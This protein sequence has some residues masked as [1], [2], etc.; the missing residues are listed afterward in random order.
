MTRPETQI[1][2]NATTERAWLAET[3]ENDA[4]QE[5]VDLTV[6]NAPDPGKL[7]T[8]PMAPDGRAGD[9]PTTQ[10][11]PAPGAEADSTRSGLGSVGDYELIEML[12]RGGMGIVYKA[13][14]VSLNRLVALKL[15]KDAE[16]ASAS[17]RLRFQNEAEAVAQLDHPHIV[18][19]YE[20]GECRGRRYFS[21]K[22]IAGTGLDKHL[23]DFLA[24]PRAAARLVAVIA[25]AV[26]HAHER[27]ILHRDLK[28]GNILVD[29]RGQPHV[30]D[31][32]LAK[33]ITTESGLTHSGAIMGTPLYMS[34]EQAS[35]IKGANTTAT[36]VYGLGSILYALLA[37]RAPFSTGSVAE[38]LDLVRHRPPEPPS[39]RNP[40]VPRDLEVICLKC[41][42]KEPKRRYPSALALAE[43]LSRWLEGK[44]IAARPVGPLPRAGMW[45]RRNPLPAG[46]AFLLAIALLGGL[47]GIVWKWREADR[48]RTKATAINELLTRRLLAQAAPEFQPR[49]ANVT[50]LD[51]LDRAGAQLGGWLNGQAD[52]EAAV[53]ET[54]GG[55]Y[56]SLGRYDKAEEHLRAAIRLATEAGGPEQPDVLR[57]VNL[58]AAVLD[59]TGRGAEAEPLIR[60]NLDASRRVLGPD[61][62][63]TLDAAERL[64]MVLWHNHQLDEAEAVLRR[65]VD[66][67][68]RILKPEHGDTLRAVYELSRLLRARGKFAEADPLAYQFAHDIRCARGPDHPDNVVALTNQADLYREAGKLD[69]AERHYQEAAAE[70]RRIFG[71]EHPSTRAAEGRLAGLLHQM[72]R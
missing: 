9:P 32:G 46:L 17:D 64:G 27:G 43:D 39:R 41:L 13:R 62:G 45:C 11:P 1:D 49:A 38:A 52:L 53:R 23:A 40:R 3:P 10:E 54:I 63:A 47:A 14:Q 21:M 59:E 4:P 8:V 18:P 31:F 30:T 22:L 51:L 5:P 16:F 66:D 7:P 65:N 70:A 71:P 15:I 56:L 29:E 42:E 28:P 2:P 26:H 6:G 24:D 48:E 37:G 50:V 20:V 36:D 72:G 58:L 33:R 55:A 25:E 57:S 44:P 60:R 19:I 67:R 68:R 34:P 12:G 69:L 61:A 35:G